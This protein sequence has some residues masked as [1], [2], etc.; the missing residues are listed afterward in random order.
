MLMILLLFLQY[1]V[2]IPLCMFRL[3]A[4]TGLLSQVMNTA[5]E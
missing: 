4:F 1:L 5:L 2:S 3:W